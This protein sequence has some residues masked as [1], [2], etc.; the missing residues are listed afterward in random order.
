MEGSKNGWFMF[1]F[2]YGN[3]QKKVDDSGYPYFRKPIYI[4]IIDHR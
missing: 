3:S 2:N 4:L 1:M